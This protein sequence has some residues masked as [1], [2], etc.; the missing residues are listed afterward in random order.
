M[1][2][3]FA[4]LVY[5]TRFSRVTIPGA[6][7]PEGFRDPDS[8]FLLHMEQHPPID[9]TLLLEDQPMPLRSSGVGV[10]QIVVHDAHGAQ[11]QNRGWFASWRGTNG[12][13]P[14]SPIWLPTP[15]F[16]VP[17][18]GMTVEWRPAYPLPS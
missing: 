7:S 13:R 12:A 11:A 10:V 15:A 2:R 17:N 4:R 16:V 18:D 9:A 5:F 14:A 1:S 8:E 3:P 6:V